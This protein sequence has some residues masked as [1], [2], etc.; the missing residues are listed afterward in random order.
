MDTRESGL[1]KL[2]IILD[3]LS[4]G[5]SLH[6]DNR[7]MKQLFGSYGPEGQAAACEFA[8]RNRCYFRYEIAGLNGVFERA[9]FKNVGEA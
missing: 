8:E 6:I 3:E 1:Q 7:S 4:L 5:C 2:K 9:I